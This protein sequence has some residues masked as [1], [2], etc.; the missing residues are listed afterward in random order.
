MKNMEGLI[1][2]LEDRFYAPPAMVLTYG[3]LCATTVCSYTIAA[4]LK[5]IEFIEKETAVEYRCCYAIINI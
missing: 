2:R 5:I 4:S 1:L 3:F